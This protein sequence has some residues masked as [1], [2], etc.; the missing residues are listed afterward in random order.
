MGGDRVRGAKDSRFHNH[1]FGTFT[2]AKERIV[3]AGRT[4]SAAQYSAPTASGGDEPGTG[5][6]LKKKKT[7]RQRGRRS[8]QWERDDTSDA[9]EA[10]VGVNGRDNVTEL[11]VESSLVLCDHRVMMTETEL[12]STTGWETRAD[13][14]VQP[15]NDE[16]KRVAVTTHCTAV[17]DPVQANDLEVG[18]AYKIPKKR[19]GA[20]EYKYY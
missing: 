11:V 18:G 8:G 15:D 16:R 5:P 20:S 12:C 9:V 13:K 17:G 3:Q 1:L 7:R 19:K 2:A 6:R 14:R 4:Q 10:R